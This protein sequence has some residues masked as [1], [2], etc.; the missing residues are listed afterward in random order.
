MRNEATNCAFWRGFEFLTH[1][2]DFAYGGI[3]PLLRRSPSPEERG[4]GRG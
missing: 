4:L 3:P 1:L 2:R